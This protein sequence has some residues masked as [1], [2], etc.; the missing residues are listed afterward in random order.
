M[1]VPSRGKADG[2]PHP[3]A[4]I[5]WMLLAQGCFA[6][7]NVCARLGGRTLPWPEVAATRFV[8]GSVLALGLA[9]WRRAPLRITDQRS[10]WARAVF[11]TASAICTFYALTSPRIALGDAATLGA[12]APIFVALLAWPLLGERVGRLVPWAVV[13]AF[14]GVALVLRPSFHGSVGVA[15]IA[16]LGA[17]LY[18]LAMLYLRRLGPGES[19]EAVVLHFSLVATATML[20]L[21]LPQWRTPAARDLPALLGTGLMGGLA[22]LAMTRA[23][24]LDRAARIAALTYLG[25]LFTHLLAIPVFGEQPGLEQLAGATLVV[26]SGLLLARDARREPTP[27]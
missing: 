17:V 20:L 18:A 3:L 24:A 7:M 1:T 9:R 27:V 13:V 16:T 4:G 19:S 5:L 11:G 22:Q 10:S 15:A 12:T 23:Y 6:T 21:A 8:I 26:A 25:I 14:L 2:V